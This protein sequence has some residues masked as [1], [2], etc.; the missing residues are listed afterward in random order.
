M[1]KQHLFLV[2]NKLYNS[3]LQKWYTGLGFS[4]CP[5]LSKLQ[6]LG[7]LKTGTSHLKMQR[8]NI[9]KGVDL[10]SKTITLH[11]HHTFWHISLQSLYADYHVK[12]PNFTF[13]GGRKKTTTNFTFSFSVN[14]VSK[15]PPVGEFA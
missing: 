3:T 2:N 1:T 10:A 4:F 6:A 5:I 11:L 8:R 7:K 12:L 14:S 9:K 13:E 15:N